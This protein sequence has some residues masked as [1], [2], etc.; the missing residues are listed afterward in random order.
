MSNKKVSKHEEIKKTDLNSNI[1]TLKDIN[2]IQDK[3]LR[4]KHLAI[5]KFNELNTLNEFELIGNIEYKTQESK[6]SI[7][8]K[9]CQTITTISWKNLF[10]K[11]K[12]NENICKNCK[13]KK[14]D[15]LHIKLSEKI[16]ELSNG[17]YEILN[18]I[19]YQNRYTKLKRGFID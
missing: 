13:N 4:K 11:L 17:E 8:H 12:K 14:K 6:V 16:K 10:Y 18:D 5:Y 3:K 7:R 9:K 19:I 15:D 1:L 2:K